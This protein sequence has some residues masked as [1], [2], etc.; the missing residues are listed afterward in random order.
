MQ[1]QRAREGHRTLRLN[2]IQLQ[3]SNHFTCSRPGFTIFYTTVPTLAA[4][5]LID[6]LDIG[7]HYYIAGIEHFSVA[8]LFLL[9]RKSFLF[10]NVLRCSFYGQLVKKRVMILQHLRLLGLGYERFHCT[11]V[12]CVLRVPT[13]IL[14]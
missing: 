10:F 7:R 12:Y 2:S 6:Q 8:T 4:H 13:N 5:T 3:T 1:N 11:S 14:R 9:R